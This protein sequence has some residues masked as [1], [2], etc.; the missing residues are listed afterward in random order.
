MVRFEGTYYKTNT[1]NQLFTIPAPQS[2]GYTSFYVNGGN[3][4]NQG[5]ELSLIVSPSLA[6]VNWN[7][8]VN[9]SQNF[10]KVIS[11][12]DETPIIYLTDQTS[13][14]SVIKEGGQLGDMY[15]RKLIQGSNFNGLP[16]VNPDSDL[17]YVGSPNPK[18]LLSWGNSFSYK[19]FRLS[20]LIDTRLGG[21]VI[22]LTE[23]ILDE[24]G[25]SGNSARD[26][27]RGYAEAYGVKYY[28]S[29]IAET[30]PG[31]QGYYNNITNGN[32]GAWG[33][34]VYDAT[35]IR[36]RELSLAYS[37]PVSIIE[38]K[39]IK[40]ISVAFIARNLFYFYKPAPI[41]SEIT[42]TTSNDLLGV[43]MYNLP[44]LRS[45]GF[46]INFTF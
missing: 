39:V 13:F 36:L 41:D 19:G 17:E 35:V 2:T 28:A 42:S 37:L 25:N 26:R 23:M 4:Q 15:A 5:Y 3:I 31:M 10:N 14:K 8:T 45:F 32:N 12:S 16:I 46:S 30:T 18:A 43:E 34:Y 40:A 24:S 22:S 9:F 1:T 33:E 6:S 44:A 29:E 38:K 27:D 21:K 20:F 11:L 7:S